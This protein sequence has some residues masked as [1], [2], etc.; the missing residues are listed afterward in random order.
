[1]KIKNI[2]IS[3]PEPPDA[4][5][6]PYT[7]LSEKYG[8]NIEYLKFF[9]IEGLTSKE[10]RIQKV[11]FLNF[12]AVIFTSKQAVDHYFRLAK[13]L[14]LEIPEGMKYF[15]IS[16]ST[17]YYLQKYVQFRKRKIFH[18]QLNF[19]DLLDVI[20]KHR[21]DKFLLPCSEIHKPEIPEI[22]LNNNI[23]FQKAVIYKTAPTDLSNMDMSKYDMLVFFSPTGVKSLF[24]NFPNYVQNDTLIAAFGATTHQA[25]KD[26]GLKLS[27]EVPTKTS[28]SM[29]MAIDEFLKNTKKVK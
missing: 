12:N 18:G 14:R 16:E 10:F 3:Q 7:K 11:D 23:D 13:E 29:T 19:N 8:L 21:E 6:S 2:L 1:M 9:V 22:L 28:P 27:I 25:V 24:E 17:A 4:E 20:K 5:K 26:M 15:C